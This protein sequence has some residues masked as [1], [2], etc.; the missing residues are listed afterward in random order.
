MGVGP[1]IT[2]YNVASKIDHTMLKPDVMPEDIKI[3][4]D[5]ARTYK[6]AS[7]CVNPCY[8]TLCR[9]LLT[10]TKVK[11]CTVIGFPLGS[12]TTQTKRKEAEQA[13]ESGAEEID[14]V[15]N[16]G[17]L[18]SGEY[19]Y[20]FN[21]INQV[22]LA[23]KK[24]NALCKVIIETALLTDEEKV[25]A[26]LIAKNAKADFVKTSTGFSKGGA[27]AGDVALMKYVVGTT[28]GVKAS[29]GVRSLEDAKLMIES[30]AD[31]IGASASVKIVSGEADTKGGY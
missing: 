30:G 18:K 4:C 23:V 7:V 31:R 21:D 26:C 16:V 12:T 13:L 25:K 27:T 9:D 1:D 20:V 24:K 6:F 14:M 10:G 5:E 11:V 2:D 8:V 19:E 3:L 15:I 29:G 28:V 22:V 17:M